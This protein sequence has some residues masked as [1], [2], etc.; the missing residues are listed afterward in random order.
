MTRKI[1]SSSIPALS[2]R[3]RVE[4]KYL[5]V[6]MSRILRPHN[7]AQ[8]ARLRNGGAAAMQ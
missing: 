7:A 8:R 3:D 6:F 1:Q 2:G 4:S 5:V